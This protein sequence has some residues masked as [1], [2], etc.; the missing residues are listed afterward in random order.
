[1]A[2]REQVRPLHLEDLRTIDGGALRDLLKSATGRWRRLVRWD[3]SHSAALIAHYVDMQA[4][5]GYAL[6]Q[7]GEM[8]GYTYWVVE[9]H[10]GLLGDLFLLD[11]WRTPANENLLL[12]AALGQLRRSPWIQRVEAQL[13]QVAARGA[14]V[15]PGGLRPRLF[16]RCFMLAPAGPVAA[17]RPI[18][19]GP[20]LRIEA[21]SPR[22][23][24]ESAELI[25]SVYAGHVDSEI[26][27]QYHSVRGA[28]RF[29]QN[30]VQYPGCGQFSPDC[31]LLAIDRSGRPCGLLL[32]SRVADDVGHVAQLCVEREHQGTGVA[33]ELLRRSIVALHNQGAAEV[34]LTVTASNA[35]ALRLYERFG[36]RTIYRFEAMVWASLWP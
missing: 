3:F 24:D 8:V 11:G 12:S 2:A 13:M 22:W 21:W 20:D 31:S 27:D 4:L 32:A 28:R 15:L 16:P 17:L 9:E 33:Y 36:F 23:M 35:R 30:I 14:Q 5:D 26:N 25:A 6:V 19:P 34:S 29:L 1:M 18:Q 10:K 7:G